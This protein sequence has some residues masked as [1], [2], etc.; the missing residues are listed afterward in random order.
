M[1]TFSPWPIFNRMGSFARTL[2]ARMARIGPGGS[3]PPGNSADTLPK[4]DFVVWKMDL[5]GLRPKDIKLQSCG[6]TIIV[7]AHRFPAREEKRRN[8]SRLE[9]NYWSFTTSI[10]LPASVDPKTLKARY[11]QGVLRIE[12]IKRPWA[13]IRKIPIYCPRAVIEAAA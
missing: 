12:E 3:S 10:S 9:A 4:R 11:V 2:S 7:E 5:P 6:N 8:R 13:R 1:K